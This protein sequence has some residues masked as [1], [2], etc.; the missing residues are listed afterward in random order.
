MKGFSNTIKIFGILLPLII[1]IS[2]GYTKAAKRLTIDVPVESEIELKPD[3]RILIY[4]FSVSKEV[5]FALTESLKKYLTREIRKS[6]DYEILNPTFK[7]TTEGKLKKKKRDK[8]FWKQL[9]AK[10]S[11]DLI[12]TG[13]VKYKSENRSGYETVTKR[14]VYGTYYEDTV[15]VE[16]T[17]AVLK[18]KLDFISGESGEK[19]SDKTI[20]NDATYKGISID[21]IKAFYDLIKPNRSEILGVIK[22]STVEEKRYVFE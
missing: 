14:T 20:K 11:C 10:K 2:P 12:I 1:L 7:N 3:A 5:D 6:T 9:G 13:E 22:G 16:R 4:D 19:L 15:Y 21:S 8:N 17:A 18:I